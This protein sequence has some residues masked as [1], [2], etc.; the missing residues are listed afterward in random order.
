[1][2]ICA[3]S[4]AALMDNSTGS[5]DIVENVCDLGSRHLKKGGTMYHRR[6]VLSLRLDSFTQSF[7]FRV[8]ALEIV[9]TILSS[10]CAFQ[11]SVTCDLLCHPSL[12]TL[13]FVCQVR[14]ARRVTKE[15]S[16]LG[17]EK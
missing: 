2:K 16:K 14:P 1:M 12:I 4:S 5:A 17:A 3:T 6:L 9:F 7:R 8:S 11:V 15:P 10:L 13:P